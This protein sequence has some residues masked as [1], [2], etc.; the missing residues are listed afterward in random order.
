MVNLLRRF[1]Q[2]IMI[3]V[4]VIIIISFAWWG[5]SMY[6]R[7]PGENAVAEIAGKPVSLEA[8]KREGRRL[9]AHSQMGGDFVPMMDFRSGFGTVRPA[10]IENS[11]IFK[12]ETAALGISVSQKELEEQLARTPA[13]LGM[14]GKLDANRFE[15]FVQR[16]LN[17]DGFSR[18]DIDDMLADEVRVRKVAA[19]LSSTMPPTPSEVKAAFI[20]ERLTTEASYVAVVAADL[21]AAQKATDEELQKRYEEKKESLKS[22]ETRKVR[23]AAFLIPATPDGKPMEE[24]KKT[25]AMQKAADGAYDL[26]TKLQEPGANF[27]ELAKAAGATLG[28][29]AGFFASDAPPEEL[30][31]AAAAAAAAFK[32]T[33]EKPYSAHITLEKGTYVLALKE[34][35]PPAQRTFDEVKKQLEDDIIGEKAEAAMKTKAGEIRTKLV[36]AKKAGKSFDEAAKELGLKAEPFPAFSMS[37]PV[38]P[39]TPNASAVQAAARK[40]APG[41][42]SEP[43]PTA[44]SALIVHVDQRPAV[45][46]KGMEEASANI[47]RNIA[48]QREMMAVMGWL[49]DRRKALGFKGPGE[50]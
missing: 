25:E 45:D 17:P 37:Q 40:L 15:A 2:P 49:A 4:T 3:V 9:L 35:K 33:P 31:K 19:M 16:V 21:R 6:S 48:S 20:R 38:P 12:H 24:S 41:E 22:P 11:L 27:D 30:E 47:A 14:D 42:I 1:G 10:A 32:L 36:E 29:T 34:T 5:P 46:E 39:G 13:F 7:G 43:I 28:E 50:S 8:Y 26:A 23:F 18:A 44:G